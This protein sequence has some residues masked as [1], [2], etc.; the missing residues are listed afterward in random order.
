MDKK[1][2]DKKLECMGKLIRE[3]EIK[4]MA[5]GIRQRTKENMAWQ[6]MKEMLSRVGVK[7]PTR[8]EVLAKN[9][10]TK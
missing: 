6:Q 7:S 4:L 2:S 8:A 9:R 5:E 1:D 3:E 10:G